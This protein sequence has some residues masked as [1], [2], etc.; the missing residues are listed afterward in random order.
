LTN[1]LFRPAETPPEL[2]DSPIVVSIPVLWGD[3]DS[4][5][6]V[7][8]AV[9]FRWFETARIVYLE[10]TQLYEQLKATGLG[11]ILAAINCNYRRQLR[12]PDTVLVGARVT[13]LGR[14]S[15]TMVHAAYSV[16]QAAI[17]AEGDSTIVCFDY[18]AGKPSP[19]PE[20]VRQ[21]L[22]QIEG[23]ELPS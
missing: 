16:N 18:K 15:M 3:M 23:R 12:Y 4:F 21:R 6:H 22:A 11:P 17:A 10:N 7:N 20:A 13:R 2:G 9:F 14:S 5:Q 19:A 8:N 1:A